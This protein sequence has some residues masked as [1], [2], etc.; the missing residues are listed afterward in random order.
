MTTLLLAFRIV[1]GTIV[2][3]LVSSHQ[4]TL[5]AV[6]ADELYDDGFTIWY[7]DLPQKDFIALYGLSPSES[8]DERPVYFSADG[9]YML[10]YEAS[11]NT[12]NI[13]NAA[14]RVVLMIIYDAK[15]TPYSSPEMEYDCFERQGRFN[16][17]PR[18]W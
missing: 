1:V 8:F 15:Q 13:I 3:K 18:A 4:C 16:Y 12:W 14:T 7:E 2:L 5:I 17:V 11:D 10:H 6:T 9:A